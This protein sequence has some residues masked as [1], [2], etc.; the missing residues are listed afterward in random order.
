MAVINNVPHT[1][2]TVDEGMFGGAEIT[3]NSETGFTFVSAPTVTYTDNT[4]GE[5]KTQAM[6]L[7]AKKTI[8]S[9]D[10]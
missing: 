5:T 10:N 8:A 4:F 7:N 2:Y 6:T 1:T 3:L 9:Y